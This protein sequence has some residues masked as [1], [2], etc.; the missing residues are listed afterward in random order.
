VFSNKSRQSLKSD[1]DK[2]WKS[3]GMKKQKSGGKRG[4]CKGSR[5]A[6][7]AKKKSGEYFDPAYE[8]EWLKWSKVLR[9]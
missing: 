5:L 7:K 8:A 1:V 9:E 3:G 2:L 6:E 4:A